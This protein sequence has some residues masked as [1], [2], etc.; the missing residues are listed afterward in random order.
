MIFRLKNDGALNFLPLHIAPMVF[1]HEKYLD[2]CI[3]L[4]GNY[5]LLIISYRNH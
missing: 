4:A 3:Y 2:T 1:Q 5:K